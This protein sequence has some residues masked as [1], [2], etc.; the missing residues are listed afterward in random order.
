MVIV[1][2]GLAGI[3]TALELLDR[4]KRVLI[5]E[6]APAAGFGGLARRAFGGIFLVATP[7][8]RRSGVE[9][10]VE[11]ALDDWLSFAQLQPEDVLPRQ[12]AELYVSRCTAEVGEWL[13]GLGVRFFPAVHWTE[14]GVDVPGNS[15]PRF[16]ITWGTGAG[17]IDVVGRRLRGHPR[18][19][20]LDLRFGHRV[21]SLERAGGRIVGCTGTDAEGR[22]FRARAGEAVV[23]ASGGFAGDL[24]KVRAR[25]PAA[26]GAVPRELLNGSHPQADGALMD[27]VGGLGGRLSHLDRVWHYAQGVKH[28]RPQHADHALQVAVPRSALW[29]GFDGRRLGPEPLMFNYDA[30]HALRRV[31]AQAKAV[32][33]AVM[34]RRIAKRELAISGAEFNPAMRQRQLFQLMWGVLFGKPKLVRE[35][36]EACEDVVV[37]DS[38]RSLAARMNAL[39]GSEDIDP[40]VLADGVA[41]FD[42]RVRGDRNDPQLRRIDEARRYRG[43]RLRILERAPIDDARGGPL[44]AIRLRV[45]TRKSLG[46]IQTDL[47]SQVLDR[48]GQP[49][50][51][52]YAVGE[53]AGFGG[54]GMHGRR[55]LEGTFLG[56]CILTGRVAA[57]AIAGGSP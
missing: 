34:N 15:V 40:D 18:A 56:G 57:Q 24:A 20:H 2:A 25:W 10:S 11:R 36:T 41:A 3:A 28:W 6:G 5:L 49:M 12:W 23:V 29:V 38:V 30:G 43:D 27:L 8:Q 17:L 13:R 35:L 44:I 31:C 51:G 16:H 39:T 4:G 37:A 55:S 48:A 45:M 46:G 32:S 26:L 50:E 21:E 7:E 9:D 22:A 47:R 33:W 14:R 52:L 53:A 54:G 1:G 42:R 19:E